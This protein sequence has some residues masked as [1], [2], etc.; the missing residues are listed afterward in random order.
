M[1]AAKGLEAKLVDTL[2]AYSPSLGGG[3]RQLLT[4]TLGSIG[5]HGLALGLTGLLGLA[6]TASALFGQIRLALNLA[7]DVEHRRPLLRQKLVDLGLVLLAGLFFAAS[8]AATGLLEFAGTLPALDRVPDVAW[9]VVTFAVPLAVLV[10]VFGFLYWTVP[11]HHHRL[12]EVWPGAAAAA[13]LFQ[14]AQFL[15]SLYLSHFGHYDRLY[16][17]LGALVAFLFWTYI[18]AVILILGAELAAEMAARSHAAAAGASPEPVAGPLRA[19]LGRLLRSMVVSDP[20][21]DV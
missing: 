8:S 16:G 11:A 20:E 7:F 13:L 1:V 21:G 19:R 3:L 5:G 10:V 2:L 12:G 9:G 14:A 4:T 18:S 6:W 15:F 17:S